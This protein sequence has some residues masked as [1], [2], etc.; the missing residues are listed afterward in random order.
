MGAAP[1]PSYLSITTSLVAGGLLDRWRYNT[2]Y[3]KD[4]RHSKVEQLVYKHFF[5]RR[6][7]RRDCVESQGSV[8][9]LTGTPTDESGASEATPKLGWRERKRA[10]KMGG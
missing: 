10:K 5:K 4:R 7:T 1:K 2:H 9:T 3:S 8:S 6:L